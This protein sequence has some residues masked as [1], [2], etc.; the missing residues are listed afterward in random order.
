MI[1]FFALTSQSEKYK[2]SS[3]MGRFLFQ[4]ESMLFTYN[5]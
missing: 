4:D 5:Q 2:I 1:T 3:F